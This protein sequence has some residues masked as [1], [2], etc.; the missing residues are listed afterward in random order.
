MLLPV[1]T[2]REV[3]RTFDDNTDVIEM[4]RFDDDADVMEMTRF[5]YTTVQFLSSYQF[6]SVVRYQRYYL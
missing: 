5:A 6:V 2:F 1:K 3:L 4:A